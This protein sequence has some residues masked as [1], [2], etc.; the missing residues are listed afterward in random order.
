MKVVAVDIARCAL[1]MPHPVRLGGVEYYTRDYVLVRVATD[2]GESGYAYGYERGTPLVE[3]L[4]STAPALIGTSPLARKGTIEALLRSNPPGR[5]SLI[6]AVS[7]LEIALWDLAA[8]NAGMPLYQLL[9]GGRTVVPLLPVC[10]Y[11]VDV[12]GEDGLHEQMADL[13]TRGFD[14]LKLIGGARTPKDTER[15]VQ[16]CQIAAGPDVELGVDV[17]YS[18]ANLDHAVRVGSVLD[19]ANISFLED[20][21]L[22]YRW[23]E[24]AKLSQKVQTPLAAGEDVSH[25]F[26]F[27]NLLESVSI[28]R[29]D[30]TTCGGISSVLTGLELASSTGATVIPHVFPRLSA[31]LAGAYP[32]ITRVEVILPEVGADPI[33]T[34]MTRPLQI[35]SG[36]LVLDDTPGHGIEFDWDA[37]RASAVTHLT[38]D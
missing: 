3:S 27:A 16:G 12:I 4:R 21:F 33:E 23:R 9:G 29:P 10:G 13:A 1:E 35:E 20:P 31:Q 26:D 15:F 37:I 17:H 14:Y 32:Q 5:S 19:A 22:P 18:F 34:A 24:I 2:T 8:K 25:P 7:L 28:L 36:Q 6:R 30:P 38:V 11:F